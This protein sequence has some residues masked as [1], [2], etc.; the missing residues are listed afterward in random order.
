MCHKQ[1]IE[2][3]FM[4]LTGWYK[5]E[6]LEGPSSVVDMLHCP[7]LWPDDVGPASPGSVSSFSDVYIWLLPNH[8]AR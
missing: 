6:D 3:K 2:V 1:R 4:R 5:A 7:R 8:R